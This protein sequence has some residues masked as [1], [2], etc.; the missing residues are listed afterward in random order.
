MGVVAFDPKLVENYLRSWVGR[1]T[2]ITHILN[3]IE[4]NNNVNDRF[5]DIWKLNFFFFYKVH[6]LVKKKKKS[7]LPCLI[8]SKHTQI[9]LNY[10]FYLNKV[11]F[12]KRLIKFKCTKI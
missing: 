7:T 8:D 4:I 9:Q 2:N 10:T 3:I 5:G 1:T 6:T 11:I 12:F